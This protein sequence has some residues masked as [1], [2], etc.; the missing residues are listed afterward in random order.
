M[1]ISLCQCPG[2]SSIHQYWFCQCLIKLSLSTDMTKNY[3][4]HK[5]NNQSKCFDFEI[6]TFVEKFCV[7]IK[8]G[9]SIRSYYHMVPITVLKTFFHFKWSF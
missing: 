5:Q 2:L 3:C 8:K 1:F 4:T 6:A 9:I 7:S